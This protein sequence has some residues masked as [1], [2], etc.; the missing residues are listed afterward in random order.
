M[1]RIARFFIACAACLLLSGAE[2]G[3]P[4][5]DLVAHSLDLAIAPIEKTEIAPLAGLQP[6]AGWNLHA[7]DKAFGGWSAL[8]PDANGLTLVS[9]AG[10]VLE[11]RFHQGRIVRRATL[12]PLPRGCA[13]QG[14][15][16]M[17]DV[18]SAGRDPAS[19]RVWL[20]FEWNNRLCETDAGLTRAEGVGAPRA[21][22]T[23]PKTG[24]PEG[25]AVMPDGALLVFSELSSAG[26][27]TRPVFLFGRSPFGDAAWPVAMGYRPPEGFSPSDAASLPDGGILVINRAFS[28]WRWFRSTLGHIPPF[29]PREGM[30]LKARPLG[31]IL[32]AE[33]Y[34]GIAI[35][36]RAGRVFVWIVSDDNFMQLQRTRLLL[37]EYSGMT[38]S[39]T[40]PRSDGG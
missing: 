29:S 38:E 36:R 16:R 17:Q 25:L 31:S 20:G 15:K 5:D 14:D 23:L 10:G 11:L 40:E 19:G 9:D 8:V 33:N 3:F 12:R 26:T 35:T 34:E 1:R 7:D 37:Y 21:L 18:E 4:L 32:P 39:A 22:A 27:G 28:P 2:R 13:P 30:V 6:V 24:G